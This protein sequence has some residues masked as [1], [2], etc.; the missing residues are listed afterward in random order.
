M[1][2]LIQVLGH[3]S[4]EACC[5]EKALNLISSL[6]FD[7]FIVNLD[8]PF[9]SNGKS[10]YD[11][12]ITLIDKIRDYHSETIKYPAIVHSDCVIR[13]EDFDELMKVGANRFLPFNHSVSDDITKLRKVIIELTDKALVKRKTIKIIEPNAGGKAKSI[14]EELAN[15]H[16][17]VVDLKKME[18]Y[19][20][21]IRL[22][23][24]KGGLQQRHKVFLFI[25]ARNP[26]LA[27][28]HK[29]IHN[30]IRN[31][32]LKDFEDRS[33]NIRSHI[34]R[35]LKG[36]AEKHPN[37]IT[38]YDTNSIFRTEPKNKTILTLPEEEIFAI[39][40]DEEYQSL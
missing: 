12:G 37:K 34:K 13:P 32:F 18:V 17:L 11:F 8:I 30:E 22:P 1:S 20:N 28:S 15:N 2:E 10:K 38:D 40:G 4:I 36:L 29:N 25:L 26:G 16:K 14:L 35:I 27:M 9:S 3:I 21:G 7:Y 39:Y 6:L 33:S 31:F 23:S 19:F 24:G 5:Y